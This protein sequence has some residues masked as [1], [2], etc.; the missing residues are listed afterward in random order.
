M[1]PIPFE[2]PF[3]ITSIPLLHG[4]GGSAYDELVTYG[5]IAAIVVALGFLSWRASRK[6][7]RHRRKRRRK[8]SSNKR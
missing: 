3:E 1:I 6:R 7:D 2:I 8:R 4:T 5:G